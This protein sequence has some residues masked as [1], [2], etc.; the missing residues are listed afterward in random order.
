MVKQAG[1]SWWTADT[2]RSLGVFETAEEDKDSEPDPG[3]L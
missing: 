1:E 2:A 3:E